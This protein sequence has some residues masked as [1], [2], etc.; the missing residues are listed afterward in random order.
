MPMYEYECPECG[1]F[2]TI[3]KFSDKPLSNCPRC[4]EAGKKTAVKRAVSAPAFHLKGSGWYKTDYSSGSTNSAAKGGAKSASTESSSGSA[5]SDT[6]KT[7]PSGKACG[8]GCG[9]H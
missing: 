6:S 4:K 1:R 2:E 7:A 9:C 3:Q 5:S 8:T